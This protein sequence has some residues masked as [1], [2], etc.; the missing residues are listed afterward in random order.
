MKDLV[1]VGLV[2]LAAYLVWCAVT[3][4][5]KKPRTYYASGEL[6]DLYL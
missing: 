2:A 3:D 5:A 1:T 4:Q 6:K